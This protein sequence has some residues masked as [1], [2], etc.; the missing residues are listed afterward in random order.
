M[1]HIFLILFSQTFFNISYSQQ[2]EMQDSVI[3]KSDSTVKIYK[4]KTLKKGFYKNRTEFFN[5]APSIII[6]FK[7]VKKSDSKKRQKAGVLRVDYKLPSGQTID[8]ESVWGFCDGEFVYVS[9]NNFGLEKKYWKLDCLGP[10]PFF[11]RAYKPTPLL[12]VAASALSKSFEVFLLGE[13]ENF[14]ISISNE[15]IDLFESEQDIQE[16]YKN[17][18]A[19]PGEIDPY[20]NLTAIKREYLH[21][22]NERLIQRGE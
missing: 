18:I 3:S 8:D 16:G 6:D 21:R 13:K 19:P 7:V 12:G 9:D 22:F 15:M 5:N 17:A 14:K 2:V 11:I 1:K 10:H 20:I 4:A